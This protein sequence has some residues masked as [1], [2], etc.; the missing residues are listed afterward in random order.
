[1]VCLQASQ[2]EIIEQIKKNERHSTFIDSDFSPDFG[3]TAI[4]LFPVSEERFNE[5]IH[6]RLA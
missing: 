5:F 4:V 6:L 3:I 2:E 1:M